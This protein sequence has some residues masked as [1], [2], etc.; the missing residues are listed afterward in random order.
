MDVAQRAIRATCG[1]PR[2]FPP[3]RAF[4]TLKKIM[5]ALEVSVDGKAI[6]IFVPPEGKP[7]VAGVGNIPGSYMRAH[8]MSGND[9]ECWRRQLPDV[10]E[11]QTISFRMIE[12]EPGSGIPPQYVRQREPEEI[13]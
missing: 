13:A 9:T 7:F 4:G 12:A 10:N 5:K 6:G 3:D 2:S 11:G 8:I 1:T